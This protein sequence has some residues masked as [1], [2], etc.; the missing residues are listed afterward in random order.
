MY[1]NSKHTRALWKYAVSSSGS[2]PQGLLLGTENDLDEFA[3]SFSMLF[4]KQSSIQTDNPLKKVEEL[5][6]EYFPTGF[7]MTMPSPSYFTK[8]IEKDMDFDI[9]KVQLN[10]LLIF[11]HID[12]GF[13]T[14]HVGRFTPFASPVAN[15]RSISKDQVEKLCGEIM[16]GKPIVVCEDFAVAPFVVETHAPGTAVIGE[17]LKYRCTLDRDSTSQNIVST[18]MAKV[19]TKKGLIQFTENVSAVHPTIGSLSKMNTYC[20]FWI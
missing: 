12:Q 9:C 6:K 14:G 16:E 5:Q 13:L 7:K 1:A 18:K 4:N 19:L 8:S 15:S 10:P 3:K 2:G 11:L 17:R 20:G